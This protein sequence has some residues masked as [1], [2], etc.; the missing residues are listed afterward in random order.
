M[1][2]AESCWSCTFPFLFIYL[3]FFAQSTLKTLHPCWLKGGRLKVHSWFVQW[4]LETC[5]SFSKT[6][7][8]L[9]VQQLHDNT[10]KIHPH[11]MKNMWCDWKLQ[12]WCFSTTC[13]LLTVNLQWACWVVK[14]EDDY[15]GS[16]SYKFNIHFIYI[17]IYWYFI[18][19]PHKSRLCKI[20]LL[21]KYTF[22]LH[23]FSLEYT[24]T[25]QRNT[26]YYKKC[27]IFYCIL[28]VW[29]VCSL[30]FSF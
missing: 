26:T 30:C 19:L 9:N 25:R 12:K 27:L 10:A 22:L 21:V 11:H 8:I 2:F 16:C 4:L 3:F 24:F 1:E 13:F 17:Y 29:L 15:N 6:R 14:H 23:K 18:Y 28:Y 20:D 5:W 7:I